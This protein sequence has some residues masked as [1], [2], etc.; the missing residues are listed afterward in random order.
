[1]GSKV[2]ALDHNRVK[3]KKNINHLSAFELLSQF[4]KVA[5]LFQQ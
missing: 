3:E 5:A 4:D 2:Y 1:M